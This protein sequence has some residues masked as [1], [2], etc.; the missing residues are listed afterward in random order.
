MCRHSVAGLSGWLM[1][2][3][4]QD[5]DFEDFRYAATL[6]MICGASTRSA[7]IA[8]LAGSKPGTMKC[9]EAAGGDELASQIKHGGCGDFGR[10]A[11]KTNGTSTQPNH[12]Q[13]A[14]N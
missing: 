9:T 4:G 8:V 1:I 14:A 5:H 11:L 2:G 6:N 12:F 13:S 7:I 10:S 3:Q